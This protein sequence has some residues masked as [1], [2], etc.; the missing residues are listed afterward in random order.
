MISEISNELFNLCEDAVNEISSAFI[1][2][3]RQ[4]NANEDDAIEKAVAGLSLSQR[5]ALSCFIMELSGNV[6]D[7]EENPLP[8]EKEFKAWFQ[9]QWD[10]ALAE[11]ADSLR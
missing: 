3:M 2:K 1:D 7:M 8:D 4:A 6:D 10:C 9:D 5:F 11:E